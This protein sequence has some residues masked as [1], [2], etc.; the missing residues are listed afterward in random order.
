MENL[1]KRLNTAVLLLFIAIIFAIF[2]N[3]I[4]ILLCW[5]YI[6]PY[7]FGLPEVTFWQAF[8]MSVL[9]TVLF[10][11]ANLQQNKSE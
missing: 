10:K 3:P 6:M 8:V 11:T 7:L 9:S 1:K 4:I 5:N 2:V